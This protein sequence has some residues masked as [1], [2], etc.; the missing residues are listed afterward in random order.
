MMPEDR[1]RYL[2]GVG[3]PEDI[4]RNSRAR[5]RYVRL[6]GCRLANAR[7]GQLFTGRGKT[8]TSGMLAIETI[9]SQSI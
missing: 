6:R 3:T 2:M 7:N 8:Q 9:R 1:P 4:V 5:R